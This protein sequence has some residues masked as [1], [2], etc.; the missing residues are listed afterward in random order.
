MKKITSFLLISVISFFSHAEDLKIN[1]AAPVFSATVQDGS[2]FDLAKRKG[3][4]T[5]LFF[6]PKAGTPGCTKQV[7]AFRDGI[8]KIRALGAD[9]FGIST[10]T[11]AEQLIFHK[12]H[13]LNFNLLADH[14]GQV[15]ELYGAKMPLLK[16]S[17]RWTF[18]LDTELKIRDIMK[19][20][21]PVMDSSRVAKKISELQ[22]P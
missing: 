10:D 17:K 15:T 2:R 6:Y 4:W 12:E 14:D 18:I 8:N 16:M 7:C 21:D 5:V 20:V 13:R 19:D 11:A 22:R 9:V 1:D 3:K